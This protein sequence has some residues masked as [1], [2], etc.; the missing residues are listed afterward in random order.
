MSPEYPE[1]MGQNKLRH[2]TDCGA[3]RGCGSF[4]EY[5]GAKSIEKVISKIPSFTPFL[6]LIRGPVVTNRD[7]G[8]YG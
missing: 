7:P 2:S 5:H 4:D 1:E 6:W 3:H 8:L